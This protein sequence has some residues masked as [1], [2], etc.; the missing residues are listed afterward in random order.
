MPINKLLYLTKS[1]QE[2]YSQCGGK[3]DGCSYQGGCDLEP[4]LDEPDKNQYSLNDRD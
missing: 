3:C 2:L 1:E 4:R